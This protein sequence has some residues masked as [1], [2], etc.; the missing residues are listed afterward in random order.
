MRGDAQGLRKRGVRWQEQSVLRRVNIEMPCVRQR[1]EQGASIQRLLL[2]GVVVLENRPAARHGSGS[3]LNRR[4]CA[5]RYP[6]RR[7][8]KGRR[9]QYRSP[10]RPPSLRP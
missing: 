1:F 5:T 2:D 10:F 8:A 4:A 9:R 6:K 3:F 7:S